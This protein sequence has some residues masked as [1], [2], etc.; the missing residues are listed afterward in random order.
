LLRRV[1]EPAESPEGGGGIFWYQ[2]FFRHS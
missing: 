1:R 2:S